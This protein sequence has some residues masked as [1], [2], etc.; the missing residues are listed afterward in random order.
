[1]ISLAMAMGH[2]HRGGPRFDPETFKSDLR[3]RG[4]SDYAA[5]TPKLSWD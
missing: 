3:G 4:D 5:A 1:M 2:L